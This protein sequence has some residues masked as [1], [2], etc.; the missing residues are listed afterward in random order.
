M[1][2]DLLMK[3]ISIIMPAYNS[4]RT[5]GASIQSVISQSY[6]DWELLVVDDC[7]KD[8]TKDI[9][10]GIIEKNS[11]LDIKLYRNPENMGVAYSRNYGVKAAEGDLIAFLDS[12]DLWTRDKLE[13]QVKLLGKLGFNEDDFLN[14]LDY[15]K[16]YDEKESE[17]QNSSDKRASEYLSSTGEKESEYQ[18]LSGKNDLK[19]Q[20]ESIAMNYKKPVLLFTGSSFI[21][22]ENEKLDYT[23]H[24]PG[25]IGRK[26][27][28]KQNI[29][30]CSSVLVS[31][32]LLL[33]HEFPMIKAPIH[34][35]FVVWI[36]ILKEITYAYGVD[37][38]LLIYRVS[39]SS[40]SS[41]KSK[42]AVMNWNT[43]R[44][45]GMGIPESIYYMMCYT[46]RGLKK[47]SRIKAQVK[48]H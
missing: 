18:K 29:I 32:E 3:K 40:K 41:Q 11:G 28:Q 20:D 42:A 37:E 26:E 13:K 12:D 23:L 7:S 4:S 1:R 14:D 21:T 5:I 2:E 30:S 24:V 47:W 17:Y 15:L 34:E 38:P 44:Y 45:V 31:K 10:N 46:V 22:S 6:K 25:K 48:K 8:E 27:L 35:D 43:Y 39:D 9:V 36:E 16:T 33:N 19:Y